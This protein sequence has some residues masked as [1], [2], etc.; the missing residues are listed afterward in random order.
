MITNINEENLQE[1]I[2]KS[3]EKKVL[4]YMY[5]PSELS[6][7]N[8]TSS[9]EAAVGNNNQYLILAKASAAIQTIQ[10]VCHQLQI[11]E[12]PAICVFFQG[13]PIDIVNAELLRNSQNIPEIINKYLPSPEEMLLNDAI[14]CSESGD[15]NGAFS[16]ISQ[17]AEL[18]PNDIDIAFTYINFALKAK[19]IKEARIALDKID[20][21]NQQTQTY[22]DLLAAVTLAE[23]NQSNPE[24]TMLENLVK[25]NPNDLDS[26]Q[27]LATA[28]NQ[29]GKNEEALTMLYSFLSKDLNANNGGIKKVYLD[30]LSTM[31]GDPL[32]PKFRR[33][34]Y[35]LLY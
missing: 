33:M 1:I 6:S 30:I 16:K 5:D 17:A 4:L 15:Y 9:L 18:K 2:S 13:R 25:E 34:L 21:A 7:Q 32:Q 29:E 28:W 27:K 14:N 35:T 11:S 8:I 31:N 23:E 24:I 10:L 19:K 20:V 12:L 3:M 26:V 22:K